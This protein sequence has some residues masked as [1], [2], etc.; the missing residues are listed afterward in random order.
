MTTKLY[1]DDQYLRTF[2]SGVLE[3]VEKDG[4]PGVILEQTAF[5]PTSGGQPYDTGTLN[6]IPVLDVFENEQRHIIHL[7]ER[8]LEAD[9]VT[10]EINWERRFDHIQQHTGQ[11]VLS[12][13]FITRCEA[14]TLSFHLGAESASIDIAASG[15]SEETLKE[16]EMAANRIIYENRDV[17]A[18]TVDKDEVQ[19]FPVRKMPTVEENI[20]IIEIAGFDYSPCGGTH[21]LRTGEIGILKITRADNYKGGTRVHFLCG[22]RALRDYQHKIDLFKN[23]SEFMSSGEHDLF[24]NV[25][26][27]HDEANALRKEQKEF[28]K[29]LLDYEARVLVSEREQRGNVFVVH[30]VF[31]DR[32]PKALRFLAQK[33]V[34]HTSNTIVLFGGR[35]QGKASLLFFRT[36]DVPHNMGELMKRACDVINGR[37]GGQPHQAQGG[38]TEL[39]KVEDALERTVESL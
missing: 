37:G 1:H 12:Q 38:G 13:V 8:P 6:G 23:L 17:L 29:H 28:M 20:R 5:Y 25:Q 22:G 33:V 26:K 18:H 9:S 10:G 39:D 7:L 11:H 31:E 32:N 4:K 19:R 16:V 34:E 21:C 3:R 35:C 30:K 2:T 14:E 15:F 36:S 27:L 24:H